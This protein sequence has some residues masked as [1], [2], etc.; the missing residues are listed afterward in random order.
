M[1]KSIGFWKLVIASVV[2][3]LLVA[4]CHGG[5]GGGSVASGGS[6]SSS[7]PDG[8]GSSDDDPGD[9][10]DTPPPE[11]DPPA[12]PV[13]VTLAWSPPTQNADG[14]ALEDLWSYRV[15]RGTRAG[16]YSIVDDVGNV[17]E[18]TTEPLGA[19]T[20]HFV[21]SAVDLAGNE[22]DFSSEV[23]ALIQ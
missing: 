4:G 8:G 12:D 15:Y 22:S 3:G 14:T 6:G 16:D 10:M 1:I 17:T 19:G 21:I 20:Y 23:V 11:E 7:P 13:P 18:Y 5:S 2:L 9:V